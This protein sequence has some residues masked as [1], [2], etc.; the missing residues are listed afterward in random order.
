MILK[1]MIMKKG[2]IQIATTT[3]Y[4]L[5]NYLPMNRNIDSKQVEA[6]VQSIREMGVTR[7][8]ICVKTSC[9]DGELKTYVIDGQHLVHA[10]QR[11][12]LP[13]EYRYIEITSEDDIIRKM[14]FYNNSSK[15]WK[16]MDYV[17][18]WLYNN[19]DYLTLKRFKNLYNLEPLMI[20]GICNNADS[21]NGVSAASDLIKTGEFRV[22]NPN[23]EAM[24]KDFS[25]LFIRIG[26][27]DRWV[28]HN[29][30]RVFIQAYNGKNYDHKK[31][32]ENVDK[33]IKTIKAMT[34]VSVANQ[35]IQKKVFNLI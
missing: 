24:C 3:D 26:K 19:P 12:D 22:T 10:C 18:A 2:F 23:A 1:D 30:L 6:L 35:F 27:A 21:Y 17:N 9:I 33:N 8:V 29:F 4:T 28:K 7:Q 25:D 34:D 14:A 15:S 32:L 13:V 31:T 5:F 11:E 16:L 20:A